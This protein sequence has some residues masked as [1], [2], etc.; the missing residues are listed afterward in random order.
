MKRSVALLSLAL[1]IGC[2]AGKAPNEA[3]P[4]RPPIKV[5]GA[6]DARTLPGTEVTDAS[7]ETAVLQ[8]PQ[9]ILVT[10]WAPWAAP[11]KAVAPVLVELAR[12]YDGRVRFAKLNVDDNPAI[13]QRFEVQGVPTM[14]VFARGREVER[15]TGA[16]P[17]AQVAAAIERALGG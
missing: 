1:V 12:E 10:F 16:V 13:P 5:E 15:V 9:P 3:A 2:G 14:I 4:V 11:A 7:F 17:K 6:P 8:S